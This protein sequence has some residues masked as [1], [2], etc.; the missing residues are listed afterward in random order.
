MDTR[1][2]N[3]ELTNF[4]EAKATAREMEQLILSATEAAKKL[5]DLLVH[6]EVRINEEESFRLSD[7]G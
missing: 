6:L 1:T 2:F 3:V 7:E 5:A 4:E